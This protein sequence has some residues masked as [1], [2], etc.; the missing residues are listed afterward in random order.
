MKTNRE[1]NE[2]SWRKNFEKGIKERLQHEYATQIKANQSEKVETKI[3]QQSRV[4]LEK[5]VC[6]QEQYLLQDS[7]HHASDIQMIRIR[8]SKHSDNGVASDSSVDFFIHLEVDVAL[9]LSNQH[10]DSMS[11]DDRKKITNLQLSCSPICNYDNEI[12]VNTK[13]AIVPTLLSEDCVT[14]MAV[15]QISG[16]K[17]HYLNPNGI[18]NHNSSIRLGIGA[19]WTTSHQHREKKKIVGKVIGS[20]LVPTESIFLHEMLSKPAS[21]LVEFEERN[22]CRT[23]PSAI[24]DYREPCTLMLKASNMSD[25]NAYDGVKC[26]IE[27]INEM[28]GYGNL[29]HLYQNTAKSDATMKLS[30]YAPSLIQRASLVQLVMKYLPESIEL[31]GYTINS[32]SMEYLVQEFSSAAKKELELIETHGSV[33][34][35]KFRIQM[36]KEMAESQF[37]TDELASRLAEYNA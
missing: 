11:V 19:L 7:G 6:K 29:T 32:A 8:Y 1:Y 16:I 4:S 12:H 26:T 22:N 24:F 9:R 25:T 18:I 5:V 13:S 14:I 27:T 36:I 33:S 2:G 10:S 17:L 21:R 15:V 28:C 20:I 34:P 23:L 31:F 35:K 30:I 37:A 3:I